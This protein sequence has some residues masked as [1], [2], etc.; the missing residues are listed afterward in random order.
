[1]NKK[2]TIH[3]AVIGCGAIGDTHIQGFHKHPQA[4]VTAVADVSAERAREL[5][6]KHKIKRIFTDY[7]ELLDQ[8]DIQAV[9]IGLPNHLHAPVALEALCAHKHVLL[10]KPMALTV[11]EGEQIVRTAREKKL[12]FMVGQNFRFLPPIQRIKAAIERGE[13][14]QLYHARAMH[15]RR[16]GI[17]RI[18]SWF[19]QKKLSGGGALLDIGV[20]FLDAS[21]HLLGNFDPVSVTGITH[22]RFGPR[23][24]G[25]GNWGKSEIDPTKP[26]DVDDYA[27][28]FIKFKDGM[29]LILEVAW[30][31]HGDGWSEDSIKV[32]GTDGSAVYPH[33]QIFKRNEKGPVALPLDEK[34]PLPYPD[35]KMVHFVDC[36]LQRREPMV[37]P[38][39]SL[40]VQKIL[41][42]IYDSAARGKEIV[43]A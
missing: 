7:R 2:D 36:I 28:A 19:T 35:D 12:T 8:P 4:R 18:G 29:S 25:D 11:A 6:S 31:T 41:N 17:P 33:P 34:S 27:A 38:E 37:Q 21:L 5:A 42:A 24:L 43:L 15:L 13:L 10:E 16:A 22:A 3:C 32:Y 39:Q 9:C 23:G 1:M 40:I 30:A 20:H 14:G 26:F